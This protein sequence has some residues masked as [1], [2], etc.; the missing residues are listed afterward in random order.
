MIT[1]ND[2]ELPDFLKVRLFGLAKTEYR[3]SED[4]CETGTLTGLALPAVTVRVSY[5]AV[6]VLLP[7]LNVT[8]DFLSVPLVSERESQDDDL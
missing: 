1:L 3:Y 5:R 6:R 7:T 4:G 8:T 2:C